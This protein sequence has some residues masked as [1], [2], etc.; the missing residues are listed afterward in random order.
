MSA[1]AGYGRIDLLRVE[2]ISMAGKWAF[3]AFNWGGAGGDGLLVN[4]DG[5]WRLIRQGGGEM[6]RQILVAFGVDPETAQLLPTSL[7]PPPNCNATPPPAPSPSVSPAPKPAP[8][9]TPLPTRRVPGPVPSPT[10]RVPA[11]PE[12]RNAPADEK[13]G[14]YPMS[15][16]E[17]VNRIDCLDRRADLGA[18]IDDAGQWPDFLEDTIRDIQRKYPR[19]QALPRWI[20]GMEIYFDKLHDSGRARQMSA[21]LRANFRKSPEAR[22]SAREIAADVKRATPCYLP[23]SS[24]DIGPSPSPAPTPTPTLTPKRGRGPKHQPTPS[25]SPTLSPAREPK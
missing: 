13:F 1:L 7:Q 17:I 2:R 6:T 19:D 21:W 25:P 24:F 20:Y 4:D 15:P 3:I 5:K 11:P 10:R 9:P 16:I 23:P 18:R 14:T 22:R 12:P 8:K